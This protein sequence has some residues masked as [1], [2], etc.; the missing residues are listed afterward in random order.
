MMKNKLIRAFALIGA[1]AMLLQTPV[2]AAGP[3]ETA[4][5]QTDTPADTMTDASDTTT[6]EGLDISGTS[7]GTDALASANSNSFETE[8]TAPSFDSSFTGSYFGNQTEDT[9]WNKTSDYDLTRIASITVTS[10][11]TRYEFFYANKDTEPEITL[12][13]PNGAIYRVQDGNQAAADGDVFLCRTQQSIVDSND[14]AYDVLYIAS[15]T[16]PGNWTL[17][18]TISDETQMFVALTS[19]TPSDYAD[20]TVETRTNPSEPFL[21]Y[22]STEDG[23]YYN[24]I[25]TFIRADS[26]G[27]LSDDASYSAQDEA[28]EAKEQAKRS[29]IR[30]CVLI[31]I[32]IALCAAAAT[33]WSKQN[34]NK[35]KHKKK[36]KELQEASEKV[37][38]QKKKEDDDL[39]SYLDKFDAAYEDDEED[40]ERPPKKVSKKA[41]PEPE[42]DDDDMMTDPDDEIEDE[43]EEEESEDDTEQNTESEDEEVETTESEEDAPAPKKAEEHR[44][45][46]FDLGGDEESGDTEDSSD[47]QD[48]RV[49]QKTVTTTEKATT[50]G[51][52]NTGAK[53]APEKKPVERPVA[54]KKPSWL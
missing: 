49:T 15:T 6:V 28:A 43:S 1:C 20:R 8:N 24:Q 21:W 22:D 32:V 34:Q 23:Q 9:N 48:E 11:V 25:A 35:I 2:Y 10:D 12:T 7:T 5:E 46:K 45:T 3:T 4:E 40:E 27:N 31:G 33:Y 26:S 29:L 53:T 47:N 51:I 14:V 18:M 36:I 19:D 16:E 42:P 44:F 52:S 38:L 17:S 13:S 50:P 41:A 39:D 54:K 30:L 37:R